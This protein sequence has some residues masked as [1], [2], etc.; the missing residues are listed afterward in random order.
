MYNFVIPGGKYL[1][2][3]TTR[4]KLFPIIGGIRVLQMIGLCN[5]TILCFKSDPI[6]V[7][8]IPFGGIFIQ[9]IFHCLI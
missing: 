6:P 2:T 7:Y 1:L 5:N 8:P 4:W 3:P 9:E